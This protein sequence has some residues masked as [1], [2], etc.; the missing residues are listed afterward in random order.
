M[1][2]Y[3][4]T[5]PK[6]LLKYHIS[7]RI[8]RPVRGFS[9]LEGADLWAR[10]TGRKIILKVQGEPAY[11]LPDHHNKCGLAYWIDNDIKEWTECKS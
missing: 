3:Q 2:L 9:T 6:K 7:G 1:I 8:I 10:K 5:T 11:K 4:V